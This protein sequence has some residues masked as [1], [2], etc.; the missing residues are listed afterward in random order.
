[1]CMKHSGDDTTLLRFAGYQEF[2]TR[3]CGKKVLWRS[4][5]TR[6]RLLGIARQATPTAMPVEVLAGKQDH[7]QGIIVDAEQLPSDAEA[8]AQR[9]RFSLQVRTS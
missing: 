2:S 1:M 8:F 4:L 6:R 9:L 7:Y 3:W 5:N